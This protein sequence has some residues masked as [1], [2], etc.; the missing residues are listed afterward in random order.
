MRESS[1][2]DG[3]TS[4]SPETLENDSAGTPQASGSVDVPWIPAS[5]ATFSIPANRL[6]VLADDRDSWRLIV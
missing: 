5:P 2:R 6:L 3:V 4:R 1:R